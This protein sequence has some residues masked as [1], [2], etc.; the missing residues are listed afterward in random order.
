MSRVFIGFGQQQYIGTPYCRA[1]KL[2]GIT[3]QIIPL[4]F[5]WISYGASTSKPNINVQVTLQSKE[6]RN[7]LDQIRSVYI[8]NM[9]SNVPIYIYF[10]DTQYSIVAQPNSAGWYPAFTNDFVVWVIGEGFFTGSIPE[11]RILI[12]NLEI[13]PAVDIEIQQSVSL[14]KASPTINRGNN[15]FNTNFGVPSL[16]D[17]TVQATLDL[18]TLSAVHNLFGTPYSTGFIYINSMY[19]FTSGVGFGPVQG[20]ASVVIESTG[21]AGTLFAIP[22]FG[23]SNAVSNNWGGGNNTVLD[24]KG[25]NIKLDATQQYDFRVAANSAQGGI[26]M[27]ATFT[28]ST[29]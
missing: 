21:A 2:R 6:I 27:I 17:Q 15:I 24:I 22:V 1:M 23:P 11:T 13:V 18:T 12:S 10:P 25:C 9:G 19:V 3:G 16:G 8:D 28:Y 14:W 7:K 20:V 26:S 5:Q 4:L 29:N